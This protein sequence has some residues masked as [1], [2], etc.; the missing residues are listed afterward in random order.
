MNLMEIRIK[1]ADRLGWAPSELEWRLAD[2]TTVEAA[3]DDLDGSL[4]IL[5]KELQRV[6]AVLRDSPWLRAASV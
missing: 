3:Q 6:R 2:P 4:D 1:M 5:V